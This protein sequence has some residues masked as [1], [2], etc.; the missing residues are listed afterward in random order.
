MIYME[1]EGLGVIYGKY[2]VGICLNWDVFDEYLG[3]KL[4][5]K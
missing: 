2:D 4:K 1:F 5:R 3:K